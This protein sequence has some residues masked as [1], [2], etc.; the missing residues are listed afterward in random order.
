MPIEVKFDP[1]ITSC[2]LER[3]YMEMALKN[4]SRI[5][6]ISLEGLSLNLRSIDYLVFNLGLCI[7]PNKK[8]IIATQI[9]LVM[10][11]DMKSETKIIPTQ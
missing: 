8:S 5:A 7:R 9:L 11:N 4:I 3:K 2:V 6:I 10:F 1:A